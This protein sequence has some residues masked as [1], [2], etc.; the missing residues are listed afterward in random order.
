MNTKRIRKYGF[1]NFSTRNSYLEL[2]KKALC[3]SA[4]MQDTFK[5]FVKLLEQE[6]EIITE[7]EQNRTIQIENDN[8]PF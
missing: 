4:E 8:F 7:M 5:R 3:L 6:Y 2:A 1:N